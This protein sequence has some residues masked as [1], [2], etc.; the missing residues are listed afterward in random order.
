MAEWV[1]G[2]EEGVKGKEIGVSHSGSQEDAIRFLYIQK[3]CLICINMIEI[4][5]P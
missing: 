3:N 4:R 2:E 1:F 5:A